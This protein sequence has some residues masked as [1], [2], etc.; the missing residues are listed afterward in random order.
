MPR[1]APSL[2]HRI[3]GN[4]A[5]DLA[6]TISWRG[7][8]KETDH[9]ADA[10]GVIAWA[11]AAGLVEPPH[12]LSVGD[13]DALLADVQALRAAITDAGAAIAAGASPDPAAL[14][15]IRNLAA[16]SLAAASLEGA[17]ARI[18]FAPA[19]QIT[20]A[21]AWAALDLLR[22]DQLDRLKQ[23]PPDDCRWLFIDRTKNRSRRWCDMAT[24]GNRAKARRSR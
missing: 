21:L 19:E 4:L 20:G 11:Q 5:L 16:R 23:C 8:S 3:A 9:L 17:P 7:T 2:P 1:P 12:A 13:R 18:A 24:C 6:N 14:A 15:T 10:D 22:S